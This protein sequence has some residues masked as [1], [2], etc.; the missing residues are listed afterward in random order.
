MSLVGEVSVPVAAVCCCNTSSSRMFFFSF[1]SLRGAHSTRKKQNSID[2]TVLFM[3][4][5]GVRPVVGVDVTCV[6]CCVLVC[7]CVRVC[8]RVCVFAP[9]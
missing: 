6:M 3:T 7:A 9:L 8:M 2:A 1:A 5:V 4:L